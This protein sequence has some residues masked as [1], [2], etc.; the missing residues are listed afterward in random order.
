MELKFIEININVQV[1]IVFKNLIL[2][3]FKVHLPYTAHASI[4]DNFLQVL[5]GLVTG[6]EIHLPIQAL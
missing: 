5:G 1:Y 6:K 3:L 4:M 2:I